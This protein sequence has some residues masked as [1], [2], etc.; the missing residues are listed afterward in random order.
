MLR[1]VVGLSGQA[2][3]FEFEKLIGLREL[4]TAVVHIEIARRAIMEA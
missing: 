2:S 3:L 4:L 1:E